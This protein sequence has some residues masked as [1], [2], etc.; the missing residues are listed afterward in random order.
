MNKWQYGGKAWLPFI[1]IPGNLKIGIKDFILD[2]NRTQMF[3]EQLFKKTDA[4]QRRGLT[5]SVLSGTSGKSRWDQ[6][7]I[8][9]GFKQHGLVFQS[10][11]I[12]PWPSKWSDP[13]LF[14]NVSDHWSKPCSQEREKGKWGNLA[15]H[16]SIEWFVQWAL[17]LVRFIS[18]CSMDCFFLKPR[19]K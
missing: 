15:A 5:V 18:S 13:F 9:L 12:S 10:F 14:V 19:C 11:L 16:K 6:Y 2:L 1:F 4:P 3:S 7:V 17:H 8:I